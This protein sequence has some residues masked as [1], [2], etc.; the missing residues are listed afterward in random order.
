MGRPLASANAIAT[1][2]RVLEAAEL[3][4][5]AVGFGAAKLAD[6]A[7]RAGIRRPSLLY[8]FGSKEALY[9]QT[10]ERCFARLSRALVEAMSAEGDF[11]TRLDRTVSRF[12]EF[13]DAEPQLAR[14]VMR[15]L[16]DEQGPGRP[17]VL[18]QVVP[19]LDVVQRFIE[20]HGEGLLRPGLPVRAAVLQIASDVL[21]KG[22]AGSLREPLWGPTDH[23][24][25]LARALLL[26]EPTP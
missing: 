12:V 9:T 25:Q 21:L 3:A 17:I 26:R 6:I 8:H 13:V 23:T 15:E 11:P 4:F 2:E 20:R 7:G 5:A 18:G 16:L 24:H 22:A 14:I 1:P 10:V 19:L